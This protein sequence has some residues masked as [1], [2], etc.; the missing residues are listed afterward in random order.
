MATLVF[1]TPDS[2]GALYECMRT[3]A[4]RDINLKKLESRP[5]HGEPWR[6]MFYV[7]VEL[8]ATTGAF[9]EAWSAL[10]AVS[11]DLRLLGT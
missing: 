1:S 6:Y 5:I 9:D 4:D 7:D 10:E 3:L 8:P 2:P 11:R